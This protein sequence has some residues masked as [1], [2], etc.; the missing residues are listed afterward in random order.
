[1]RSLQLNVS[2]GHSLAL[3]SQGLGTI[4]AAKT[5]NV[6]PANSSGGAG[7]DSIQCFEEKL[8]VSARWI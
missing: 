4:S 5:L 8:T 1:M 6:I 3:P 7:I 2:C